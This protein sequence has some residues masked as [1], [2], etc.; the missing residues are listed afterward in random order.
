[1]AADLTGVTWRKSSL[2]GSSGGECVEVAVIDASPTG[3]K[4]HLGALHVLRDSK[5]PGGPTL[6]FTRD[7][8]DVFVAGVKLGEF[9]HLGT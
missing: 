3:H 4:A 9:D 6:F 5:D 8:W 2:S 7:E 1:M